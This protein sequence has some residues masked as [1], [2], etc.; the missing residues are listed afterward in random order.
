MSPTRKVRSSGSL[1][2]A[3]T[4]TI[5][6]ATACDVTEEHTSYRSDAASASIQLTD[7]DGNELE[8]PVVEAGAAALGGAATAAS[9]RHGVGTSRWGYDPAFLFAKRTITEGREIFRHDTFGNEVFWGGSLRLHEA[10]AGEANGGVGPGVSPAAALGLGLKVD[11]EA[12][13]WSLRYHIKNGKV[14]LEDPA[15]TVELLRLDAVIGLKGSFDDEGELDSVGVTCA[16]CHT[17]VDDALADGIGR[18]LDGWPNRDLD[19]G[20][21]VAAAPDLTAVTDLLGVDDATLRSVVTGWGR[22]KFDAFVFLDGKA[23]KPDGSSA[24]IT[25]PPLFGLNG[26]GLVTWNGFGSLASWVPLVANVEIHGVGTF[27]DRRLRDEERYPVAAAAGFGRIKNS[28]DLTTAKM[29]PLQYYLLSLEPPEAP[30][31]SYD[32]VA[33]EAGEELFNGKARCSGCHVPPLFTLPGWNVVPG[34]VVG[35][36]NF[37]ADRSPAGGYRVPPL[38]G[39]FTRNGGFFHDG[40]FETVDEVVEH[41]DGQFGLNLTDDESYELGEYLRSL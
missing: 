27:S 39:L 31:G 19:I 35:V 36:D 26:V 33:A 3:A 12:L 4:T 23:T 15:T 40:R 37:H 10:I 2:L 7:T 6:L 14:D 11:L 41:F 28:P 38:R 5:V 21:I 34:A 9:Q 32:P 20:A 8:P 18:R 1:G 22:G 16:L 13:P 25:I 24:A 17:E 30:E 29:G